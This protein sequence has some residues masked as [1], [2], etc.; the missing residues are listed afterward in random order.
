[1]DK[2]NNKISLFHHYLVNGVWRFR[3]GEDVHKIILTTTVES[4]KLWQFDKHE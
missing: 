4:L 3:I 1:L 2:G